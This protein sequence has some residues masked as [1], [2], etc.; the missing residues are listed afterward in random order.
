[1]GRDVAIAFEH[2]AVHQPK[3]LVHVDVAAQPSLGI[4]E[5]D[6]RNFVMTSTGRQRSVRTYGHMGFSNGLYVRETRLLKNI[7]DFPAN[8]DAVNS[9][10]VSM[11]MG[12]TEYYK[13][14]ANY[15]VNDYLA[16]IAI[17]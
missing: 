6:C 2:L 3:L 9:T 17:N 8:C 12:L 4:A 15:E 7:P 13:C 11:G 10:Q 1:M 16:S 14:L 5:F